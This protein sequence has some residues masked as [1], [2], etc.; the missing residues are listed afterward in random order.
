MSYCN[1]RYGNYDILNFT[2]FDID[3]TNGRPYLYVMARMDIEV[4]KR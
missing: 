3:A 2:V 4:L 1:R